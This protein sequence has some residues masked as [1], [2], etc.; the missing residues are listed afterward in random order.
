VD[1]EETISERERT[2]TKLKKFGYD[3][4]VG[5]K[6]AGKSTVEVLHMAREQR[7][8]GGVDDGSEREGILHYKSGRLL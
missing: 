8:G 4:Y 7:G 2:Y 1:D 5:M 3:M 6:R